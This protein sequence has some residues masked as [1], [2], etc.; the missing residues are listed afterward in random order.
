MQK[1]D[2]IICQIFRFVCSK[3]H[4]WQRMEKEREQRLKRGRERERAGEKT[5]R[6]EKNECTERNPKRVK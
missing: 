4:Q 2:G 1:N 3:H 5:V 6:K